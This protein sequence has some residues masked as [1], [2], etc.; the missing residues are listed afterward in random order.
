MPSLVEARSSNAS[1]RPDYIPVAVFIGGTGGI[2]AEVAV[3]L[4][5]YTNGRIHVIIAGRNRLDGVKRLTTTSGS[6]SQQLLRE[7]VFC[8]ASSLRSV[9]TASE[10]IHKLLR[11]QGQRINF[12]VFSAGY[13]NYFKSF[14]TM[15]GL[16][17]QLM[18][19]Y[20]HRFKMAFE[21]MPLLRNA[22]DNEQD[23][24]SCLF[25]VLGLSGL[26]IPTGAASAV[27]MDIMI[28]E[29]ASRERRNL[30]FTYTGQVDCSLVLK[31]LEYTLTNVC[32]GMVRTAQLDFAFRS[33]WLF[34]PFRPLFDLF[35]H[36]TTVSAEESAEWTLFALFDASAE[37]KGFY[38]RW[39]HGQELNAGDASSPE[40]KS[41]REKLFMHSVLEMHAEELSITSD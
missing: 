29:F 7:F 6:D 38:R 30:I 20:Y 13:A 8:D 37:G 40:R 10:N 3:L 26:L 41:L 34:T 21:L 32:P 31:K 22:R 5:R 17:L 9:R 11:T 33:H 19:R 2:A 24:N 16:D 18:M 27:Y 14:D 23:A 1:F 36:A 35:V 4:A 25:S 28:E 12:L 15:D 39:N